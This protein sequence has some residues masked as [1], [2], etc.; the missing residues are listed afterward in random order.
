MENF[1]ESVL[2]D[3][4]KEFISDFSEEKKNENLT[5]LGMTS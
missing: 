2:Y 1:N 5:G 3:I 4:V